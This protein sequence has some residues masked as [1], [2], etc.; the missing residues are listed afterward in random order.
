MARFIS[1]VLVNYN[2]AKFLER[3]LSSLT[4]ETYPSFEIILVDNAST[5]DSRNLIKHKF[6]QVKV[7][8]SETNVGFAAGN[9][10]GL[11]TARGEWI[12][13]LNTDTRS[14]RII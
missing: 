14:N 5:D 13:T 10:L 8:R 9:N 6:A 12:A 7:L 2:G 4:A 11:E 3:C 1:V